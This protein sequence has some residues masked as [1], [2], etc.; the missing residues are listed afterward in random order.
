VEGRG[1]A[2]DATREA[3]AT[4]A[5]RCHGHEAGLQEVEDGVGVG[6]GGCSRASLGARRPSQHYTLH[7]ASFTPKTS[8]PTSVATI[9]CSLTLKFSL[10]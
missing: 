4:R 2:G 10:Y 1:E 8:T 6:T 5:G 7:Y 9:P 3:V